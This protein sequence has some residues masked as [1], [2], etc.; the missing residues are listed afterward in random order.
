MDLSLRMLKIFIIQPW[1]GYCAQLSFEL[2]STSE[3]SFK[4]SGLPSMS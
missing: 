2:I 3:Q 4:H 1:D